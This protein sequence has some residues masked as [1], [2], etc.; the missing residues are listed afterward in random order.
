MDYYYL[1]RSLLF[2]GCSKEEIQA[3]LPCFD[4][5]ER[6][7]KKGEVICPAGKHIT[8]IGIV[9]DGSV[10]I[11]HTNIFGETAILTLTEVGKSFGE[12][13][14]LAPG[15]AAML[16]IVANENCRILFLKADK[17]M[18]RCEKRC[19]FHLRVATNLTE[20]ISLRYLELARRT[21]IITNKST[22]DKVM[23]F[24]SV[25]S[26]QKGSHEFDIH[27]S[28]EQMA[29]YLG[30]DRSALSAE[31]SRMKKAGLIDF[32]KNHFI[33]KGAESDVI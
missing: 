28:R 25:Y 10:R 30:V 19:P 7:Y 20:L 1:K 33:L 22:R 11:E 26:T 17:V 8:H 29:S 2:N 9:L 5:E 31:L 16:D 6:T 27:Y 23:A 12:A 15:R 14:S 32:R 24:L 21:Y 3:M 13:Y 18:H 4:A